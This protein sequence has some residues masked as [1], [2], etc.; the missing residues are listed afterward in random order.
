MII[1]IIKQEI[2]NK[3]NKQK[4]APTFRFR[5]IRFGSVRFGS[6]RVGSVRV[7][8]VRLGLFFSV[9]FC[10]VLFG[11]ALSSFDSAA[12]SEL[13]T[14]NVVP[15]HTRQVGGVARGG[16][17]RGESGKAMF[18]HR[19]PGVS[20]RFGSAL[21]S[22]DSAATFE[23]NT[24]KVVPKHTRQVGGGRG[25]GGGEERRESDVLSP[26]A[27]SVGSRRV[28]SLTDGLLTDSFRKRDSMKYSAGRPGGVSGYPRAWYSSVS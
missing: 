26:E 28:R 19:V 9:L 27:G 7:G 13:N 20:I 1:I 15:K 22:F 5:R 3:Q 17:R 4:T 2:K 16:G 23:L 6:V 12:I 25:E 14:V 18:C 11:S 21:I 24:V 10:S 8:S